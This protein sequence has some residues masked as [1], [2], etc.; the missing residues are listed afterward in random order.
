[1]LCLFDYSQWLL[2]LLP[3]LQNHKLL[4]CHSIIL[5][6]IKNIS[7]KLA[8]NGKL[9]TLSGRLL[10]LAN[11]SANGKAGTYSTDVNFEANACY[12]VIIRP[13]NDN[14]S[15]TMTPIIGGYFNP[16]YVTIVN[17]KISLILSGAWGFG[18][19]YKL[20]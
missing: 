13:T 11:V 2:H 15:L 10:Q 3:S 19:V 20:S 17:N 18:F 4:T 9:G 1:M 12:I 16:Q 14:N 6:Y 5:K 8:I 7:N